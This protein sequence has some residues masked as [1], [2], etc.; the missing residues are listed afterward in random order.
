MRLTDEVVARLTAHADTMHRWRAQR[1]GL[2][3]GGEMW[4]AWS[5]GVRLIAI[6]GDDVARGA[7]AIN[8]ASYQVDVGD[9]REYTIDAD[10]L[11][12]FALCPACNGTSKAPC[13]CGGK[14]FTCSECCGSGEHDCGCPDCT[15][16]DCRP[17]RGSGK[18][19][20]DDADCDKGVTICPKCRQADYV[21]FGLAVVDRRL[22]LGGFLDMATG[23]LTV[24]TYG[25]LDAVILRCDGWL[26]LVMPSRADVVDLPSPPLR[27][28]ETEG[29]A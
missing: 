11:R 14:S 9:R 25:P 3:V 26:A 12:A 5:D 16:R 22:L 19:G 28:S 10:A 17:C 1:Y 7:K 29:E 24:T 18:I 21:M 13:P 20:C 6:Q 4:G 2:D 8:L 23:T 15:Q 27:D